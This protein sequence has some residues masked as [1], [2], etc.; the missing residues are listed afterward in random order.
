M[1]TR[2]I[3]AALLPAEFPFADSLDWTYMAGSEVTRKA[4]RRKK[5]RIYHLSSYQG[6]QFEHRLDET[7]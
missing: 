2:R 1:P 3:V 5:R 7:A 6:I 4:M